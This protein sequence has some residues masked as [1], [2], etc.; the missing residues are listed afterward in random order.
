MKTTDSKNEISPA[1]QENVRKSIAIIGGLDGSVEDKEILHLLIANFIDADDAGK[2]VVFLPIAF[3]R[4]LL[5]NFN[6]KDIYYEKDERNG[7]ILKR[8]FS[9]TVAYTLTYHE[10]SRYFSN[11]PDKDLILK[12]ASRSSEFHAIN[13]LLNRGGKLEDITL[14]PMQTV[15]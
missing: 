5:P 13:E 15:W 6:W 2:I 4:Q 10:V 8:N 12:I 9:T 1:F 3:C 7:G 14:T 11:S